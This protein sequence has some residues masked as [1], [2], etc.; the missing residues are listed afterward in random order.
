[1]GNT[2]LESRKRRDIA[3][4][5]FVREAILEPIQMREIFEYDPKDVEKVTRKLN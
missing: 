3:E 4:S 5:E 1:M 2:L